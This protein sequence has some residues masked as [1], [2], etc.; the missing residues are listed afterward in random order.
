MQHAIE[1]L[2]RGRV[3]P[4]AGARVAALASAPRRWSTFLADRH[5]DAFLE[6]E[7]HQRHRSIEEIGGVIDL[8][9]SSS[10][11]D[12]DEYLRKRE[13][14]HRAGRTRH[15]LFQQEH[16]AKPAEDLHGHVA[17]ACSRIR[18]V[19][20]GVG[21]SSSLIVRADG[22]SL[23]DAGEERGL[24]RKPGNRRIVLDDDRRVDGVGEGLVVA[25][26]RV[27]VQFGHPRRADHDRRRP[28]R[29]RLPAC[30]RCT[31]ASPLRSS[32]R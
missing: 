13:T 10:L 23:R 9:A 31:C 17:E 6:L 20:N 8:P 22:I 1:R 19:L 5:A 3:E 26:D 4:P 25:D 28:N 32:R 24:H 11:H 29:L 2:R 12:P 7:A 30:T 18:A 15:Q 21:G 14:G 27:R 16:A